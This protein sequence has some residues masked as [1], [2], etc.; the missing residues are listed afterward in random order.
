MNKDFNIYTSDKLG[1]LYEEAMDIMAVMV[2]DMK[3]EVEN[4]VNIAT[5][6]ISLSQISEYSKQLKK[7]LIKMGATDC[8]LSLVCD[9]IVI[10]SIRNNREVDDVAWAILQ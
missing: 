1:I 5:S 7:T 3:K 2:L 4:N 8:E 10:N 9:E 6:Q